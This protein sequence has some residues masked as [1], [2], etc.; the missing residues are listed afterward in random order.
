MVKEIKENE[1]DQVEA[2]PLAVVD[3]FATWCGPCKMLGPVLEEL[4]DEMTDV[5]FFKIDVDDAQDLA[6]KYSVASIPAVGLFKNGQFVEMNVG[7]VPKE[8][9]ADFI[10]SNR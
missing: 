5:S 1:F 10:N 8:T 9:M 2:A 4:S 7:F 3:F 6:Q